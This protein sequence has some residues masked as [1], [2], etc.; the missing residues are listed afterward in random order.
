MTLLHPLFL[1]PATCCLIAFL[2]WR[3]AGHDDWARVASAPVLGFLRPDG[4]ARGLNFGLLALAVVL[5][6]LVSPSLRADNANAYAL[7]EGIIVLADVSKSMSLDDIAPSRINAARA[8]A[9][10]IS[11]E[12]GARPA[13]LIAYSGDAYLLEPFAVDRRQFDAFAAALEVGLVPQEGSNLERALALA[14]TVIDESGVGRV[15]LVIVSDGGGFS[16]DIIFIARRL[17]ERGHRVDVV[18]TADPATT[19]PVVADVNLTRETAEAG[20]GVLVG[21]TAGAAV[22]ITPLD[23]SGSL[24]DQGGTRELALRST[25]WRNLSHFILLLAVPAMLLAFWQAR[26]S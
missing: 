13:A 16:G 4:V 8:A 11:A 24:L 10:Q 1:I 23:L 3:N 25:D 20:G 5:A 15:R 12:A 21:A 19:S 14:R 17:A 2:L 18:F 22:D 6:G 9:L 7:D 26:R